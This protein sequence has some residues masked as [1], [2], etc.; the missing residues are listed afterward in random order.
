M[1]SSLVLLALIVA[2]LLAGGCLSSQGPASDTRASPS[3]TPSASPSPSD[4]SSTSPFPLL[5]PT[6]TPSPTGSKA[7]APE[8]SGSIVGSVVTTLADD[9]LR[10]RSK[11][12]VSED[13]LKWEL[14]P[15]GTQLYV[16]DG[17]VTAS[18][19]A[20]YE[21]A[22]LTSRDLP[23][24]IAS[25]DRDGDPWIA[26][27]DIDCPPQPT[28]IRALA[29]LPRGVGLACFPGQ[30]ITIEARLIPCN[31][32]ADGPGYTP[33]WF[34]LG[35]GS[36]NLLVEPDVT[37]VPDNWFVL[38]LDPT[39][40][41]PD[42]LPINQVVEVTGMFDHPAASSCTRTDFDSE[43]VPSQ[44]CRLEFAVTQLL[45]SGP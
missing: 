23:G 33:D 30:P 25:A 43:P 20:W 14:L 17:P 32:D 36:P 5:S 38:N 40:E 16:L 39:G 24:W 7:A 18:G 4:I 31:C 1:R 12:G 35:S 15:L 10:V 45:V 19:Y 21:V 6:L 2:S 26:V 34:F 3:A 41:H 27:D 28:N 22:S 9:G 29:A 37:T 42:V 13:S 8:P 11:P 44:G